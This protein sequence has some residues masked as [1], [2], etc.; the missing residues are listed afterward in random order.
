MSQSSFLIKTSS[1]IFTFSKITVTN[2]GYQ[3]KMNALSAKNI[4]WPTFSTIKGMLQEMSQLASMPITLV[5]Q[6]LRILRSLR[7]L[8]KKWVWISMRCI[9]KKRKIQNKEER[10]RHISQVLCLQKVSIESWECCE[11]ICLPPWVVVKAIFLFQNKSKRWQLKE[12][13]SN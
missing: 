1:K 11:Q 6:R 7:I 3:W 4:N 13:L 10:L 5:C 8:K 12:E 9:T 2:G